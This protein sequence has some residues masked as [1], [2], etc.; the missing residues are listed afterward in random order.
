MHD[1]IK[2]FSIIRLNST[3]E[4]WGVVDDASGALVHLDGLAIRLSKQRAVEIAGN[5]NAE[6]KERASALQTGA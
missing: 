4:G 3:P 1:K 5:L 2:S 6:A